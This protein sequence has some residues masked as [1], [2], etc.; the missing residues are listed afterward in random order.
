MKHLILSA[1][2]DRMVY[3]VPDDVADHTG[4]YVRLFYSWMKVS[5]QAKHLRRKMGAQIGY[6]FNEQDFVDWLNHHK[7]RDTPCVFVKNLGFIN[8]LRFPDEYKDC[9]WFNF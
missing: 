8:P 1:D 4:K 5:R 6:C 3:L 9:P 7:F 2:G